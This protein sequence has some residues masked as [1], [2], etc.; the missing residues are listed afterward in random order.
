[1]YQEKTMLITGASSGIGKVIATYFANL[2]INL[3]LAYHKN[4]ND[5][6]KLKNELINKY[7][8]NV[9]CFYLDLASEKSIK[10]LVLEIRNKYKKINYLI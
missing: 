9:D 1:M 3:I 5:V 10:K 7:H 8:V 6:D 2:G 4:Y